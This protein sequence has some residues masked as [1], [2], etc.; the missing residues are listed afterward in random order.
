M[1]A[2]LVQG[3]FDD[4]HAQWGPLSTHKIRWDTTGF[5]SP[6]AV[7]APPRAK[8]GGHNLRNTRET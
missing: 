8:S 4:E 2:R 1:N 3:T 5:V 6:F 7:L